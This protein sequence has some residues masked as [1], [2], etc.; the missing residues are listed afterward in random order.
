MSDS[1]KKCKLGKVP[2][3]KNGR[4]ITEKTKTCKGNKVPN[5]KNGRC[6]KAK[7]EKV[8]KARGPRK[9]RKMGINKIFPFANSLIKPNPPKK[10]KV[11][12]HTPEFKETAP[13]MIPIFGDLHE[14]DRPN[15]PEGPPPGFEEMRKTIMKRPA[16]KK[17]SPKLLNELRKTHKLK[18][19]SSPK[20]KNIKDIIGSKDSAEKAEYFEDDEGNVYKNETPK[21]KGALVKNNKNKHLVYKKK[22]FFGFNNAQP[23]IVETKEKDDSSYKFFY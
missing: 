7:T 22:N 13:N 20:H 21:R 14:T 11:Q 16:S 19:V 9:T 23:K 6:I 18:K 17:L 8:H 2:K 3:G 10:N 4:C 15:S 12:P 5:G 1:I